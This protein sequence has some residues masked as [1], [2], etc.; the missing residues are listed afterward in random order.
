MLQAEGRADVEARAAGVA[1]LLNIPICIVL[2]PRF[3]AAGAALAIGLATGAGALRILVAYHRLHGL[4]L[5]ETLADLWLSARWPALA[6]ALVALASTVSFKL[7]L[8]PGLP[9]SGFGADARLVPA[10]I[11]CGIGAACSIAVG[12]A[13]KASLTAGTPLAP[14]LRLASGLTSGTP[15]ADVLRSSSDGSEP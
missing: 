5:R 2:V 15:P 4:S 6:L 9:A 11:A 7:W 13:G 10:L 8:T 14:L 3:G 1:V 12:V